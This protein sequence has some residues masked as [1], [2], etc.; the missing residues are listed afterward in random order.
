M[1]NDYHDVRIDDNFRFDN[2]FLSCY[3]KISQISYNNIIFHLDLREIRR[4]KIVEYEN[5]QYLE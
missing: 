1:I 2:V 5:L 3:D 4:F